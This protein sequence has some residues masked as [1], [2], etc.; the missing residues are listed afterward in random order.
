MFDIFT[1]NWVGIKKA[2]DKVKLIVSYK[3]HIPYLHRE[4]GKKKI[5]SATTQKTN[6]SI[7][8]R[9]KFGGEGGNLGY[10]NG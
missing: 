4:K 3:A 8:S 2:S 1:F 6:T 9:K 7:L 5:C 10:T